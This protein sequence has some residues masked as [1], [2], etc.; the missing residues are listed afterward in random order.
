[1]LPSPRRSQ[2]RKITFHQFHDERL[3]ARTAPA[4]ALNAAD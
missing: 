2:R 1:M 3:I 4:I